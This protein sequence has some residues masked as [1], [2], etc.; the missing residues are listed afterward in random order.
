MIRPRKS[1]QRAASQMGSGPVSGMTWPPWAVALSASSRPQGL[2]QTDGGD[3]FRGG[4]L[5]GHL[6]HQRAGLV[7]QPALALDGHDVVGTGRIVPCRAAPV[8][9]DRPLVARVF[10]APRIDA[11]LLAHGAGDDVSFPLDLLHGQRESPGAQGGDAADLV[12]AQAVAAEGVR[13]VLW[14]SDKVG[15]L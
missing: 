4:D 11:D 7:G 1:R 15:E 5:A 14:P 6:V 9:H 3:A 12:V 2:G 10:Q 8:D 13:A